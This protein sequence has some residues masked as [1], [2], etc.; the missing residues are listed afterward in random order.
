ME[1]NVHGTS[2]TATDTDGDGLSDYNEVALGTD[3][4]AADGD[5]DGLSDPAE[6]YTY[7][8]NPNDPDSDDDGLSD[9][10]EDQHPRHEPEQ[11]G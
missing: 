4:N 3:P 1:V 6:L 10:D 7:G 5:G 2:P 9:G 8:T 11:H